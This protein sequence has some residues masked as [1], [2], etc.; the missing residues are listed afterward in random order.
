MEIFY[1][2][3]ERCVKKPCK[4]VPLSIGALLGNTEGVRLLGLLRERENAYLG[5]FFFDPEDI[6]S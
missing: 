2:E 5:S 4:Q 1:E 3:F 6:K